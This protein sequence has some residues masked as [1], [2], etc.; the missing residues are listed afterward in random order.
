MTEQETLIPDD[1]DLGKPF[2][3]VDHHIWAKYIADGGLYLNTLKWNRARADGSYVGTCR[4]CGGYLRPEPTDAYPDSPDN[5]TAWYGAVC[6]RCG[7]EFVAPDG[8][9]LQRSARH[10]QMPRTFLRTR[11]GIIA[12]PRT[13]GG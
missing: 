12:A 8:K 4:C 11:A 1:V 2:N 6:E 9:V 10:S 13:E 7:H 5:A 3:P